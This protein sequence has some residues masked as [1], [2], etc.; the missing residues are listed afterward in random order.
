MGTQREGIA[1]RGRSCEHQRAADTPD[2]E[3]L[4]IIFFG[5]AKDQWGCGSDVCPSHHLTK[6][7]RVTFLT[8]EARDKLPRLPAA[9]VHSWTAS[10]LIPQVRA[11]VNP[12][13]PEPSIAKH[14][15]FVWFVFQKKENELYP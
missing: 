6:R 3:L 2:S 1:G 8:D 15:F 12:G 5:S 10:G 7:M 4:L 9:D 11:T 14:I 13:Q